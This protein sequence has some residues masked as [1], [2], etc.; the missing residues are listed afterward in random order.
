M[1]RA[2][3]VL[4]S[5]V[6]LLGAT[7]VASAAPPS[8][9]T[10]RV[11]GGTPAAEGGTI[12]VSGAVAPAAERPVELQRHV[13]GRWVRLAGGTTGPA[14]RFTLRFTPASGGVWRVRA[15]APAAAGRAADA[16]GVMVFSVR[17]ETAVRASLSASSVPR[18][19]LAQLTGRLVPGDSGRWVRLERRD[20]AAWE[21]VAATRTGFAGRYTFVLPTDVV[22]PADYRVVTGRT[23]TRTAATSPVRRLTVGAQLDGHGV[24][25]FA[26]DDGALQVHELF[27]AQRVVPWAAEDFVVYQVVPSGRTL[28]ADLDPVS[29]RIALFARGGGLQPT[30]VAMMDDRQCFATAEMSPS[31]RYVVWAAGRW[32]SVDDD[33]CTVTDV[34]V[35]DL[36]T[37]ATS[38]LP[39]PPETLRGTLPYLHVLY[40]EEHV[41]VALFGDGDAP[42]FNGLFTV[43][44]ERRSVGGSPDLGGVFLLDVAS[45]PGTVVGL[46]EP[47]ALPHLFHVTDA[48]VA[49]TPLAATPMSW[50]GS[51][52][53]GTR[54]AY[55]APHDGRN[56]LYVADAG[57][58]SPR[59]LGVTVLDAPDQP[60]GVLWVGNE[61]L[62]TS[63]LTFDETTGSVNASALGYDVAAGTPVWSRPLF[64][65]GWVD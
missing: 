40:G 53:D 18:N 27:G 60:A 13:H 23:P 51:S 49:P 45:T 9:V 31:G 54:T 57:F 50:A 34:R 47:L 41:Q 15:Y 56:H 64:V 17:R 38:R 22:G 29:E 55:V 39:I 30:I 11:A 5:T 44:G 8:T 20:G 25:G 21:K 4:L 1:R 61:T 58:G 12:V 52:P 6:A 36:T 33:T 32:A 16:S 37:G 43:T 35:R 63:N 59:D 65:I 3:L 42:S 26:G 7:S 14:G 28:T 10:V 62:V 2:L 19:V 24:I 46:P 48:A